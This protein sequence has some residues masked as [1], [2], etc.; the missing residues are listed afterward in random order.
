MQ[1][2]TRSH[3]NL[4]S[5]F[6]LMSG[7]H[8]GVEAAVGGEAAV[9]GQVSNGGA[10]RVRAPWQRTW[11]EADGSNCGQGRGEST[12]S[13]PQLLLRVTTCH[14]HNPPEGR[15]GYRHLPNQEAE[16]QGVGNSTKVTQLASDE[17][18][19][20]PRPKPFRP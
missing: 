2:K 12:H 11:V 20:E 14:P 5:A 6:H 9:P 19:L 17:L 3:W 15:C 1:R 13:V 4:E 10:G 18:G 7:D 16:A 8:I